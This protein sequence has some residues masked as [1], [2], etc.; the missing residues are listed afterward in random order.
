MTDAQEQVLWRWA[1]GSGPVDAREAREAAQAALFEVHRLRRWVEA[2]PRI[3]VAGGPDDGARGTA[4][5]GCQAG[6]MALLCG[7][8][9]ETMLYWRGRAQALE[10]EV[11][12]L[13]DLVRLLARD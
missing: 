10:D 4:A 8:A 7:E 1:V 3:E 5:V 11:G 13:V 9:E 12:R 6:P 2:P